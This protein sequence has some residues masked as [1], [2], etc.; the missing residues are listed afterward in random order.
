MLR[1]MRRAAAALY[2][3]VLGHIVAWCSRYQAKYR[4]GRWFTGRCG[5]V[6]APGWRWIVKDFFN[7]RR[8][9]VNTDIPWPVSARQTVLHPE[10]ITFD[11]DDL[12][13]F[14]SPGCY[15]Q[16]IGPIAI[17][18]GTYIAPNV[19]LI[20]SNHNLA[21]PDEHAPPQPI[22]LGEQCWIGMNSM[23]LPGVELGPH[24]VVGAGAVVTKSFP[25][26]FCV[27]AGNPARLI[28]KVNN[29]DN[30]EEK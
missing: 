25:E 10:N 16:A 14:Q 22:I 11:P 7:C 29:S 2:Y 26:G 3:Y 1:F 15:I 17:G 23:I 20:T 13:N 21:N 28:K 30:R 9:D 19:G 4:H 12:N 18:R 6:N 5:G 24:T 27:I 8:L